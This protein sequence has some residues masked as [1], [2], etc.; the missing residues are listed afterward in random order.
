MK[1]TLILAGIALL[2]LAVTVRADDGVKKSESHKPSAPTAEQKALRKQLIEKYD[3][4]K[5]GRLDKDERAKMTA[6]DQE[7]WNKLTPARTKPAEGAKK[8]EHQ[9]KQ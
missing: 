8:K 9:E 7:K 2:G 6:E 5:N 1:K 4:N 3:T